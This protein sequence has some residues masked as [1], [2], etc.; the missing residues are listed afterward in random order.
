MAVYTVY[1]HYAICRY[2][3]VQCLRTDR[4]H[5]CHLSLVFDDGAVEF[6]LLGSQLLLQFPVLHLLPVHLGVVAS[7][8]SSGI[9][10]VHHLG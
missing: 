8:A 7:V 4:L 9:P 6:L 5:L 10:P 2:V 3:G 1:S